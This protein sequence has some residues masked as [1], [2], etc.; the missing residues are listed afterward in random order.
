MRLKLSQLSQ[1]SHTL[2]V[3]M[4]P[5]DRAW[6]EDFVLKAQAAQLAV[7][8]LLEDEGVAKQSPT[9][10]EF[11]PTGDR[12]VAEIKTGTDALISLVRDLT[13]ASGPE[14]KRRASLAVT[15]F[16]QGAMWAVKALFSE[17][18][19]EGDARPDLR[20]DDAGSEESDP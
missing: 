9:F 8:R 10:S 2:G 15:N 5:K 3:V 20:H 18:M 14:T 19:V 6:L 7:S 17:D 16:E 1:V 11:N 13:E 12:R 4:D